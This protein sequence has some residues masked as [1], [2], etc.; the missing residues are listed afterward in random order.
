MREKLI[1]NYQQYILLKRIDQRVGIDFLTKIIEAFRSHQ[2][3]TVLDQAVSYHFGEDQ[4]NIR[5]IFLFFTPTEIVDG[6]FKLIKKKLRLRFIAMP[7]PPL[8]K[9]SSYK[10]LCSIIE[11]DNYLD[12]LAQLETIE[13]NQKKRELKLEEAKRDRE[14][15]RLNPKGSAPNGKSVRTISGGLPSLGKRR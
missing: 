9:F 10:K 3:T 8:G 5:K 7:T 12:L 6:Q 15:K 4:D 13:E 2:D 14:R 11:N 1:K